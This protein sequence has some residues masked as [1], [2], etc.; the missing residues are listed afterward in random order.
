MNLIKPIKNFLSIS[1]AEL[2]G[3]LLGLITLAYLARV[4]STESFGI[5][6]FVTA[7]LAYF[8]IFVEFGFDAIVVK[9]ISRDNT[10][11]IIQKYVNSLVS[12]KLLNAVFLYA[13]LL[14]IILLLNKSTN[15]KIGLVILGVM[16]FVNSISLEFV[17][18]GIEKFKYLS[19]K[20]IGRS[21]LYFVLVVNFVKS[22][23][24]LQ[25]I[26]FFIVLSNLIFSLWHFYVY[27]N[28]FGK[29][30]FEINKPLIKAMVRQ[31]YPLLISIIMATIY[32]HLDIVML[33]FMQ[34]DY[35]VGIYNAAYK[36]YLFMVLPF[37]I[38][39][40]VFLPI[41]S[42]FSETKK[43]KNDLIT[44]LVLM[45]ILGLGLVIPMLFFTEIALTF[46][47]GEKYILAN[48]S[49]KIL[50]STSMIVCLSFAFGNPLIVWGKQKFHALALGIGAILNV[51]MNL[52]LI[53]SYSYNGAALATLITELV[54]F[55]GLLIIFILTTRALF[56][57][58]FS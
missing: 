48:Y 52:I 18:Q 38:L 36:I 55:I 16:L 2:F 30:I 6:A 58:R 51:I 31:S 41:L 23:V 57:T 8:Q 49:L 40:K 26:F 46:I 10:N 24:H 33:G 32:N 43:F 11:T 9:R 35:D 45:I 50:V 15:A 56:K 47:F 27:R 28:Y 3:K 4:I 17:F 20:I 21:I 12:F 53:P 19:Y 39:L 13:L 54:V 37:N 25:Y 29:Y 14:T 1:F 22:D 44:F 5:V 34:S 42:R 7:F